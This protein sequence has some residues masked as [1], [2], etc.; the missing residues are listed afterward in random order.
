MK[1]DKLRILLLHPMYAREFNWVIYVCSMYL[2][3]GVIKSLS[4]HDTYL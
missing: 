4:I 3:I 1:Q 2:S